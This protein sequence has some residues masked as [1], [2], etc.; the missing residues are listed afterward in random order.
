[1][2]TP[3]RDVCWIDNRSS[4]NAVVRAVPMSDVALRDPF[5]SPRRA[6]NGAT[7][8]RQLDHL[9]RSGTLANFRRITD[10]WDVPFEGMYFADSD[11]YKWL[12]A[13]G[14]QLADHR[15]DHDLRA[16]AEAVIDL[17]ER[18][19]RPDGYLNSYF[20]LERADLRWTNFDLHEMYCAG[21]LLQAA[22]AFHRT[23]GD[24]RLLAIARRFADHILATFGPDGGRRIAVDGHEEI[25]LGLIEL[26][27]TTRDRRYLTQ[28][29]FFV[30]AR[31][32][33]LL[34]RPY[35]QHP[36]EYAQDH[37]PFE[38]IDEVVG[39]AVRALYYNAGVADLC[40]EIDAP[41]YRAALDA[42]WRN[43][44]ER[45]MY[46]SGG[47]G[48]RYEG[49]SFGDDFE[50]PHARAYTETCAAIA[51]VMWNARMLALS[52]EARYAD[53]LEWTLLNAVLPGLSQDGERT[54]YQ[55]PLAD[56]GRHRRQEWFG[57]AC[58]PPNVARTLAALPGLLYGAADDALFVHLYA[59]GEVTTT[60]PNGS[61]VALGIETRYPWEP[62]VVITA[63]RDATFT[64]RLRIPA[65]C[66]DAAVQVGDA[67][68]TG[69]AGGYLAVQ[70]AW[71]AGEQATLTL[72]LPVRYLQAH[73]RVL[74]AQGRAAIAR[75]PLL[76]CV[77]AVDHPGID[78][79]DLLLPPTPAAFTVDDGVLPGMLAL[80][81][82]TQALG[83]DE[84]SL[85][86][87]AATDR[88][89]TDRDGTD[90]D[91]T[92]AAAAPIATRLTA[93]PYFAWANR[94]AGAM[95]VWLPLGS[96]AERA[97]QGTT[98][99]RSRSATQIP[100]TTPISMPERK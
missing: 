81:A 76:Y 17:L 12:E 63:R 29:E 69:S 54:F 73:R 65:W 75:G 68:L 71:R 88:D 91:A 82:D 10:G 86:R 3:R 11:V 94:A 70:R 46:V 33:G 53:L 36:P 45:R 84:G 72:P 42:Q 27:R 37:A 38:A 79:R 4:P 5:W 67:V 30:A 26:Y 62:T 14:W 9:E 98:T 2:T 25:E 93:I 28:A 52:G 6:A 100:S 55:N 95:Q 51:S 90:R 78:P 96:S 19:Q 8:R 15:D 57:V 13:V 89:G 21:H 92:A 58:C 49:E 34:G 74:E 47:V 20:A 60:L 16:H 99:A 7:L 43:M 83:A 22:V 87:D 56:D 40:A 61:E 48:S 32:R 31:G 50:L 35:G 18:A 85:Y 66:R 1:M 24:P 23:A 41:H 97:A 39:H 59:S 44:T 80:R 77:E 64:L